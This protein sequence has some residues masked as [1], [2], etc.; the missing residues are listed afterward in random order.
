MKENKSITWSG[1][2]PLSSTSSEK[3]VVITTLEDKQEINYNKPWRNVIRRIISDGGDD[4]E[5][6]SGNIENN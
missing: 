5:N 4:Y 3:S 6:L 1:N 2:T